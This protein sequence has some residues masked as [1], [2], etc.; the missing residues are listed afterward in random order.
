MITRKKSIVGGC[1]AALSTVVICGGAHAQECETIV[2]G[3]SV[4]GEHWTL[5]GSPYCVVGDID[6][7]GVI[8]D[9]GVQVWV[10]GDYQIEFV[11]NVN[12]IGT[13][14]QPILFTEKDEDDNWNGI[15]MNNAF[16]PLA[17]EHCIIENSDN[18]GLNITNSAPVIDHCTIRNNTSPDNGGGILVQMDEGEFQM[19]NSVVTGNYANPSHSEGGT[20]YGGG[21]YLLG[22][23]HAVRCIIRNNTV[24]GDEHIPGGS[25][26]AWGGGI[27]CVGDVSLRACLIENNVA[28]VKE[29]VQGST[30]YA[31]GGG[32]YNAGTL[33]MDNCVVACNSV[34]R[35]GSGENLGAGIYSSSGFVALGNSTFARNNARAIY[36]ADGSLEVVNSIVYFNNAEGVQ[37]YPDDLPVT[38]SDVQGGYEGEGNINY[39][40]GFYGDDC[41]C[42]YFRITQYSP[43]VDAGNPESDYDDACRPPAWGTERNDMGAHGGPLN[44]GW[45]CWD[46][47][48]I[49]CDQS[50][51]TA[52]LLILLGEWG[53]CEEPDDCPAD[54]NCDGTVNTEDLLIL[55]GRWGS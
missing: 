41:S 38:Y 21:L 25:A 19:S 17:L 39:Q 40:P 24:W 43:C 29:N 35:T 31:Y 26:R 22:Q 53:D 27:A 16:P 30:V 9:P 15:L 49:N 36:V 45:P 48:D 55:L 20:H 4:V 6:M 28:R 10:D 47:A 44:C 13:E 8:I 46:P 1:V 37:I 33:S 7:I 23:C 11:G 50:V 32:I 5:D 18:R 51:N 3:G 2:P 42:P 12:A 34:I 52:D 54:L 14:D